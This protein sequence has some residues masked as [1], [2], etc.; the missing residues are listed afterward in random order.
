MGYET[1]PMTGMIFVNNTTNPKAPQLKGYIVL[2][3]TEKRY[4]LSIWKVTDRETGQPRKD[5]NGNPMLS[6]KVEEEKP[7][8]ESP[9]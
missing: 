8:D 5:K 9:F 2:D 4:Q 7:R 3:D 6:I 1:K